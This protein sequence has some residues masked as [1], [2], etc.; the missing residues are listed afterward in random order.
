MLS[1]SIKTL[2]YLFFVMKP[3][4]LLSLHSDRQKNKDKNNNFI[5]I[6]MAD[7][8][9]HQS[10]DQ[11]EHFIVKMFRPNMDSIPLYPLPPGYSF[12]LYNPNTND[13]QKWA[14]IATTA[15]EFRS[16]QE[17]HEYFV[18]R[19]LNDKNSHLLPERLHFLVNPEGRYIGTAMAWSGEFDGEETRKPFLGVNNPRI[20]RK[21]IS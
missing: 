19:F 5:K 4:S 3:H 16:I 9:L 1:K 17:G 14:E 7:N 2:S 8:Y 20:S 10:N 15:G 11:I 6:N 18:K 12:K 13:D 21:K